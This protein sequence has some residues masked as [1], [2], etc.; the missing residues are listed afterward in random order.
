MYM[1]VNTLTARVEA[2]YASNVN[3]NELSEALAK[4]QEATK[5]YLDTKSSDAL[6]AYYR[7]DQDYRNLL[8]D[9]NTGTTNNQLEIMEKNIRAQSE[10]YLETVYETIQAKRGRNVEKYKTVNYKLANTKF[11]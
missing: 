3:L 6:N 8:S 7:A 2:V 1:N 10:T 4:V 5:N 11:F 9:L